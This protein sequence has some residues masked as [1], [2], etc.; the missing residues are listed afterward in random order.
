MWQWT[1]VI[2]MWLIESSYVP[3]LWRLYRVKEA[4]EFSLLFP[5][6]NAT[7]RLLAMAYTL[8][9]EDYVL[10]LGFLCGLALRAT[11]LLQVLYYRRRRRW[12]EHLRNTTLG[13]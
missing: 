3:Q 4:E 2:A 12:L 9:R 11:L 1:A 10:A 8:A 5:A 6:M 7:G 13:L